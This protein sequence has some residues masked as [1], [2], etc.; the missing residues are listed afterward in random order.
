MIFSLNIVRSVRDIKI[1]LIYSPLHTADY[2]IRN[3]IFPFMPIEYYNRTNRVK[4]EGKVFSVILSR[5]NVPKI[6]IKQKDNQDWNIDWVVSTKKGGKYERD[7]NC[8]ITS[9]A[10]MI[11]QK[12]V[13]QN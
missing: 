2:Y 8:Q 11:R 13:M 6:W 5:Y 12:H 1:Y 3:M 9:I 7:A 10:I 4:E